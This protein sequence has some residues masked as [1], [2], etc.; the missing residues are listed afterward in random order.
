MSSPCWAC[1]ELPQPWRCARRPGPT[2][3]TRRECAAMHD[4]LLP[5]ARHEPT[6]VSAPFIWIGS[7][8]I[9][10]LVLAM[11]LVVSVIYPHTLSDRFLRLPLP[12]Y[13]AP[14]L[15]VSTRA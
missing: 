12:Q 8:S 14:R 13:P 1:S 5:S 6:D 9:A 2:F 3:H 11:V 7:A 15:Q 10:I 4:K